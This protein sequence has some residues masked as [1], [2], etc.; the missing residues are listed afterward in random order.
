VYRGWDGSI[1]YGFHIAMK[2]IMVG[3]IYS[4]NGEM[5]NS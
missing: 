2:E 5:K 3:E 4:M 1:K